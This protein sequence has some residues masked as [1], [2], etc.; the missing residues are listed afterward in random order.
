MR[1]PTRGLNVTIFDAGVQTHRWFPSRPSD[2]HVG[3]SWSIRGLHSCHDTPDQVAFPVARHCAVAGFS[4]PLGDHYLLWDGAPAAL[5]GHPPRPAQRPSGPQTP[6]QLTAQLTAA[7]HIQFL[8]NRFVAH[9]HLRLVR[10][11]SAQHLR[12]LLRAPPLT[13]PS[14]HP[15]TQHRIGGQFARFGTPGPLLGFGLGQPGPIPDPRTR[16]PTATGLANRAVAPQLPAN[17]R[18]GPTQLSSD[19]PH[20]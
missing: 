12:D 3:R 15:G 4:G 14:L 16:P 18:R 7:L 19:L 17:R 9:L 2:D 11:L 13:Q 6:G 8:V 10:E 5:I 1:Q 20:A